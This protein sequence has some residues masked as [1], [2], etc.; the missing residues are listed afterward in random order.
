MAAR[1]TEGANVRKD[2]R[3]RLIVTSPVL[4]GCGHPDPLGV[5]ITTESR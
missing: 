5:V 1:I 2:G 4:T 3:G